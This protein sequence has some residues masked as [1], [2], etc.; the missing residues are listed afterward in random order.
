MRG[1]K[2]V[3]VDID[4]EAELATNQNVRS[5]PMLLMFKYGQKIDEQACLVSGSH[6][7]E[8]LSRALD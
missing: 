8:M 5:V 6:L 7:R 1:A 3:C 2:I 4:Q